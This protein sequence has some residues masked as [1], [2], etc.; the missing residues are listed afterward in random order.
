MD[1]QEKAMVALRGIMKRHPASGGLLLDLGARPVL[2]QLQELYH[3]AAKEQLEQGEEDGY[4]RFML[5]L[6]DDVLQLL[7]QQQREL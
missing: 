4:A 5:K 1:M 7:R 2:R 3:Q 6:T